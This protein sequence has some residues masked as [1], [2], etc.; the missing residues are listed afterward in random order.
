[1]FEKY[2]IKSIN[3]YIIK[4]LIGL[5]IGNNDNFENN[6]M[7]LEME[8]LKYLKVEPR[9]YQ[10]KSAEQTLKEIEN[11]KKLVLIL[12]PTGMGKTKIGELIVAEEILNGRIKEEDKV[13]FLAP[14]RK[15]KHQLYEVANEDGLGQFGNLFL[16]PEGQTVPPSVIR[17]HFKM[18][19]FIFSTSG[20]LF[21]AV[22]P[23]SP[24]N[25]KVDLEDMKNV[26]FIVID[27]I[28]EVI[29]QKFGKENFRVNYR[30]RP[31][32]EL[33]GV[34]NPNSTNIFIG[35]TATISAFNKR[36]IL[37]ELFGGE[38]KVSEVKPIQTE[39]FNEY[40]P[41]I[42]VKKFYAF[43]DFVKG[44]DFL[45]VGL[46]SRC[47]KILRQAHKMLTGAPLADD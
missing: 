9:E 43:D 25:R 8:S 24:S 23:K 37:I 7:C 1:M 5:D 29:A 34:F 32:L 38:E 28:L 19:K 40:A 3:Q 12:L 27:E 30:F 47:L 44:V 10:I 39:D 31:I 33:L 45:I 26:K 36:K 17:N 41:A 22:F 6:L 11:G 46:N 13:L 20:L 2:C 18:S 42:I 4:C 15:M 14:D 35:L 21:N 16:F